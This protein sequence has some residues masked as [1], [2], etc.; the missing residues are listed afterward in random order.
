MWRQSV[1]L[2]VFYWAKPHHL[3]NRWNSAKIDTPYQYIHFRRL[4]DALQWKLCFWDNVHQVHLYA[5]RQTILKP[6]NLKVFQRK[7]TKRSKHDSQTLLREEN[8]RFINS[9]LTRN[10]KFREKKIYLIN[11]V[12][13][14]TLT[15]ERMIP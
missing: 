4:V 1:R 5:Q 15:T 14:E 10:V 3:V 13:A 6:N 7:K 8:F 12:S 9:C 11:Y 2:T